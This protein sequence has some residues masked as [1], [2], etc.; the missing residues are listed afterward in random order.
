VI[1]LINAE[2]IK[3]ASLRGS[4]I[5]LGI[6]LALGLATLTVGLIFFNKAIGDEAPATEITDRIALMVSGAGAA[7]LILVIV[8][9]IIFTEEI[10][11]RTIIP[12][13]SAAP[14]R[15]AVAAAKA[16][17]AVLVGA[18]FALVAGGLTLAVGLVGLDQQGFP[19]NFDHSDFARAVIGA[20]GFLII[21]TLFGLGL[22]L[23]SNSTTFG[24]TF[25][26]IWPLAIETAVKGF[27]P[28][29]IDRFLPFEAG[30]AMFAVPEGDLPT[31]EGGA[32]FLTWAVALVLIGVALFQRRDLGAS[33]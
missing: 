1:D 33:G 26:I 17:L 13:M 24:V 6:A 31:W 16:I 32:I 27:A 20:G 21:S 19:L 7:G 29:W 11:S 18:G 9:V 23:I 15:S 3:F 14:D 2:W 10:K 4:W 8:G 22:G 28:D 30:G 12:T 5:R 25:A